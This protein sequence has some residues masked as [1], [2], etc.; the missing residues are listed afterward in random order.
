MRPRSL[1]S[2]PAPDP[3]LDEGG[4]LIAAYQVVATD[5]S[6]AANDADR[7]ERRVQQPIETCWNPAGV[8]PS[9]SC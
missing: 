6:G 9:Y 1:R 7:V 2:R 5:S 4:L 3:P 8:S